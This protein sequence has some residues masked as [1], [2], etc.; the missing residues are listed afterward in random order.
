MNAIDRFF[1]PVMAA[2]SLGRRPRRVQVDDAAYVL[3]RDGAGLPGALLDR[4]PHRFAPLSRGRVRA[5]GRLECPYHGW[6]FDREGRGRSPSQP[7]LK[8]C[9]V[10]AAQVVERAGYLWLATDAADP[11]AVPQVTW[12]GYEYAGAFSTLFA[13]PLHVAL[14]NFSED[15]HTPWVHT[16]LGWSDADLETLEFEAVNH[17]DHTEVRYRARQ[18]NSLLA[19]IL[20][21]RRGDIFNNH[22]RTFFDPVRTVYDIYWTT[23]GDR[24]ERSI[25]T[26]SV[27]FFVPE[28]PSRTRLH[29]FVNVR[30][31]GAFRRMLPVVK[32]AAVGLG[33]WEVR[34]DQRF[35][36]AI[37]ATPFSMK[38]MRLGKYDKPLVHNHK[39]LDRIYRAQDHTE[40]GTKLHIVPPR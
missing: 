20:G 7:S 37:A 23:P 36:P 30:A 29:V 9:D 2:T 3:F 10:A 35:I 4:C 12:D 40:R 6:N 31:R 24:E 19:T 11:A 5:D 25:R 38:G 22:W 21:V 28:G 27:I 33:W 14:D 1:H 15:E 39:L 26:R 34:D 32:R 13:A 8:K 17:D 18:R 16:R